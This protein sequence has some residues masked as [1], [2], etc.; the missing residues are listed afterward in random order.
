[1]TRRHRLASLD[2]F[3]GLAVAGMIL[4][5]NPGNWGTTFETVTHA[6]WNGCTLAD[7][8]F[9]AFIFILGASMPFAFARRVEAGAVRRTLYRRIATR[10]ASLIALGL[11]LN[12][13]AAAPHVTAMRLPGVLQRIGLVYLIAAL[14]VMHSRW[15]AR[16]ATA[17]VLLLGHWALL[18]APFAG[19][20]APGHNLAS[21]IDRAVFGGHLL[22]ATGDPE[23]LLGTLPAVAGALLGSLAGNW[24]RRDEPD[25]VRIGGLSCAGAAAVVVGLLWTS[26][27]PLNKAL[28]TG[29]F[30]LVTS[31]I[32]CL[33]L[34]VCYL[35]VDVQGDRR[36][37]A[38]FLWLGFNP[39][40]IYFLAELCAHLLD[41][42]WPPGAAQPTTLRALAY[43]S[44]LR[45]MVPDLPDEWLSLAFAVGA[46]ACWTSVAGVLYRRGIRIQV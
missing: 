13:V 44:A 7:L 4:V 34:A 24:L 43:W 1:V 20:L 29:S 46:V 2:V 8:V 25:A 3:R 37:A 30:V 41:A 17:A 22:N 45:P 42:P 11:V 36:W 27:L 35:R 28:W 18:A 23:G 31:G 21:T 39:L 9:P 32:A 6:D 15:P 26:V 19:G 38:P 16:A 12:V 14:I 5:N 10:A 33:A 40:A